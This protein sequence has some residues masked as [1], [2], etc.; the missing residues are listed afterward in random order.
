MIILHIV[1]S[2]APGL[3][4]TIAA[5]AHPRWPSGRTEE[6][7]EHVAEAGAELIR[8]LE[9]AAD[10]PGFIAQL[11]SQGSWALRGYRLSLEEQVA[12]VSGDMRW[13]EA[14]LGKLDARLRT[15]PECRLQQESW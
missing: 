11:S 10:D 15:W 6:A 9:R 3:K 13:L 7:V 5:I 8:V 4:K 1:A 2:L 14:R 12:L